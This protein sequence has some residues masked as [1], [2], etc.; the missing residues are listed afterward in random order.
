[1]TEAVAEVWEDITAASQAYRFSLIPM[2][3]DKDILSR[4]T[5]WELCTTSP[6]VS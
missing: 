3:E 2:R 6:L 1:M 4:N 5:K